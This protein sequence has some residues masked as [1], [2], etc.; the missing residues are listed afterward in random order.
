[1]AKH[2]SQSI[3]A[4][5]VEMD[6]ALGSVAGLHV[7]TFAARHDVTPRQVT[8]DLDLFAARGFVS[9]ALVGH[10]GTRRYRHV[11]S[12]V[13]TANAPGTTPP[14]PASSGPAAVSA[15]AVKR[16]PGR[17]RKG[18]HE[19]R[20]VQLRV[21]KALLDTDSTSPADEFTFARLV[22]VAKV[23]AAVVRRAVGPHDPERR[24]AHNERVGYPCLLSRG[25]VWAY[26][27]PEIGLVYFITAYGKNAID[28]ASDRI[29]PRIPPPSPKPVPVS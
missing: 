25:M 21:L 14:R 26:D 1:M 4:R 2:S 19:L 12:F 24:D 8:R 5:W 27:H 23:S 10:R 13:F 11:G 28:R 3:L 15:P 7:P 17:P 6:A 18:K 22:K 20:D 16:R 29:W 9:V